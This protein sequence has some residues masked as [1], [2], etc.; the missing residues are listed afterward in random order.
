M[1]KM[2]KIFI[3]KCELCLHVKLCGEKEKNEMCI[4]E[5]VAS[6]RHSLITQPIS[7]EEKRG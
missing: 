6:R 2:K 7:G 3:D 5:M 1:F 4:S